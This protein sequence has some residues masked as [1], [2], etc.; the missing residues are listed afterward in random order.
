M[1]LTTLITSLVVWCGV[2]A[3]TEKFV[4]NNQLAFNYNHDK[5]RGVNLGGWLVLEPWITPSFFD[6]FDIATTGVRDEYTLSRYLGYDET[7]RLLTSHWE[8]WITFSDLYQI[9]QW[10]LN[11]IRIPIGYW[12]V[13]PLPGDPYVQGQLQYLDRAVQWAK[14]LGLKV[15]VDLHGAPGS[16]NG[17]DNSGQKDKLEWQSVP[18]YV[19]HTL[20]VVEELAYRYGRSELQDTVAG[21]EV[22][23]EPL[24]P[25]LNMD[26]I[27]KFWQ[28]GY[29][30]IRQ[31][32]PNTVVVI[33]DAFQSPQYWNGFMTRPAYHHVLLDFHHYQVFTPGQVAMSEEQHIGQ[34]CA[35]GGD[36]RGV[37]KWTVVGEWSGAF[38]DCAKWLNGYGTGS[39]Y[40]GENGG[41]G[42]VGE[43]GLKTSGRVEQLRAYERDRIRRMIEA[44]LDAYEQGTGW[45]FWTWKTQGAPEWDMKNLLE[46]G[47]FPRPDDPADRM[48]PGQCAF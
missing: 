43:C 21:I 26:R 14:Q 33:G 35:A 44:Q 32:N 5:V 29:A 30:R 47:V 36:I 31:S 20:L 1:R 28:D 15:W 38:T 46:Q 17:F 9:K 23:N 34:A 10:G 42:W 41:G 13:A 3:S 40:Q 27:R 7:V 48:W 39:R 8:T 6:P 24:G 25:H 45:I 2:F 4:R 11:H 19:E 16:Q 18:G 22:L 37:D 12:A